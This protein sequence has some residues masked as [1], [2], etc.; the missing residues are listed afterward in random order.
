MEWR[1][2]RPG[3]VLDL[4]ARVEAPAGR[5]RLSWRNRPDDAAVP[6]KYYVIKFREEG[7]RWKWLNTTYVPARQRWYEAKLATPGR[8]RFH[9]GA[10]APCGAG[11]PVLVEVLCPVVTEPTGAPVLPAAPAQAP[12]Q[13]DAAGAPLEDSAPSSPSQ[14]RD[15]GA[16]DSM[17]A[18]QLYRDAAAMAGTVAAWAATALR[19]GGAAIL[20]CTPE[21][22]ALVVP[23][24]RKDGFDADAL[25]RSGRLRI[26]DARDTL[27]RFLV[28]GVPRGDR[29]ERVISEELE[30]VRAA[31]GGE[32]ARIHAWG[33]MVN[34]LRQRGNSAAARQLEVMW[35]TL[36]EDEA[37]HLLCSY[38]ADPLAPETYTGL[39][40]DVCRTHTHLVRDDGPG[41]LEVALDRA[42]V[43]VFGA[44]KAEDARK[45]YLGRASRAIQMPDAEALLLSIHE[46]EPSLGSRILEIA[47]AHM[48]GRG[49]S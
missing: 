33:E 43:E 23:R 13:G 20:I 27:S 36:V 3:P 34:V 22:E 10:L 26:L 7:G 11:T 39:M 35:S 49:D 30:G 47:R 46:T 28:G 38:Q 16:H 48:G 31:C 45:A 44:G 24:L 40:P 32:E 9:V 2:L 1:N 25:R 42:L 6:T 17:H 14:E 29:F 5:A 15:A 12:P 4:E 19:E 8:Y 41:D 18:V 21:H 37:I